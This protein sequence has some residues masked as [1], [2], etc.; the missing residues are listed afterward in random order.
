MG[1]TLS[2]LESSYKSGGVNAL[3]F[4]A[5]LQT[6]I[7]TIDFNTLFGYIRENISSISR[8]IGS[9]SKNILLGSSS[10]VSSISG[11][12]FQAVMIG[13]F[14]FFI[15]LE[16]HAIR[17]FLYRIVPESVYAYMIRK[18]S[19]FVGVLSSWIQG[20]AIL[21]GAIFLI[22]YIGLYSLQLFGI[23]IDNIFTLALI[24]GLMEFIP[25]IGPFLALLPALA[26]GA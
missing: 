26:I 6:Y 24:A 1:D 18:E 3:G 15:M 10:L 21:C 14:T 7:E 8:I 23:K 13:V 20:Q 4:P 22:T 5:F 19:V 17:A 16:R 9:V 25:Y 2:T 11:G 12:I